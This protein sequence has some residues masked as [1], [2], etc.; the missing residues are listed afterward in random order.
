MKGG[1]DQGIM[2]AAV[3][4]GVEKVS[5]MKNPPVGLLSFEH[6][7]K[8]GHQEQVP[9]R[10]SFKVIEIKENKGSRFSSRT[11]KAGMRKSMRSHI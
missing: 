8:C 7:G 3:N 5:V 11:A 4:A 6:W 10:S 1:A 9:G 2:F